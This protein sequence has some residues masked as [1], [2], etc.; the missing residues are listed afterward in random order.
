MCSN[1]KLNKFN[2]VYTNYKTFTHTQNKHIHT[3][4]THMHAGMT[5]PHYIHYLWNKGSSKS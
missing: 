5:L 4:F 2:S 1:K 3:K